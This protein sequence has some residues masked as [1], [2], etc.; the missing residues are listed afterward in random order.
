ME[1]REDCIDKSFSTRGA[2]LLLPSPSPDSWKTICSSAPKIINSSVFRRDHLSVRPQFFLYFWD[3]LCDFL[4]KKNEYGERKE[5]SGKYRRLFLRLRRL[6]GYPRFLRPR[7]CSSRISSTPR[8]WDCMNPSRELLARCT[9][10]I[11]TTCGPRVKKYD[12]HF[13]IANWVCA[14]FR[15][16]FKPLTSSVLTYFLR[17]LPARAESVGIIFREIKARS[18]FH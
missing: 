7:F 6:H 2:T 3:S 13:I 18:S 5:S 10:G 12:F 8:R 14:V 1:A 11:L 4:L 15:G 16:A 9:L 17:L